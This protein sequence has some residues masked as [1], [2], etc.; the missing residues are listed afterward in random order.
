MI[1]TFVTIVLCFIASIGFAQKLSL[2]DADGNTVDVKTGVQ[3]S[4][5]FNGAE[6]AGKLTEINKANNTISIYYP[7]VMTGDPIT[8]VLK[9]T[10]I[11]AVRYK[12]LNK[13]GSN[14]LVGAGLTVLTVGGAIIMFRGVAKGN[15]S[16]MYGGAAVLG[17][18]FIG[19]LIAK[20]RMK[21]PEPPVTKT[22]RIVGIK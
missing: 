20:K 15:D 18:A 4:V 9:L 22:Y 5:I 14:V 10:D 3:M 8:E 19:G 1:K 12:T 7:A 16:Q 6:I 21:N 17:A 2:I 11:E 13:G